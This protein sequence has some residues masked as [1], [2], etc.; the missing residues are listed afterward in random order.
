[1]TCCG[2]FSRLER[3]EGHC[4]LSGIHAFT[5]RAVCPIQASPSIRTEE[6]SI[7]MSVA[8]GKSVTVNLGSGATISIG[9]LQSSVDA[10]QAAVAENRLATD[11]MNRTVVALGR[12]LS[13]GL[14]TVRE[15][16]GA[17]MS[18]LESSLRS[19]MALLR[20]T[21]EEEIGAD[22]TALEAS[23]NAAMVCEPRGLAW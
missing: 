1:M 20:Q 15:E 18:T 17:S 9:D 19:Q 4:S 10:T 5:A 7:E 11:A 8:E 22:L 16:T 6:G 3:G 23:V 13:L 21:T 2:V 12:Q 14:A